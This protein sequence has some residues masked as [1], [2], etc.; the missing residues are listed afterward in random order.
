M[1]NDNFAL[2]ASVRFA[3]KRYL[4][5]CHL[6]YNE[7]WSPVTDE[8]HDATERQLDLCRDMWSDYFKSHV[9]EPNKTLKTQAHALKELSE[10]EKQNALMWAGY[11]EFLKEHCK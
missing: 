1:S 4:W 5:A 7:G 2:L 9:E 11:V 10:E 3:E 8:D 6:Y